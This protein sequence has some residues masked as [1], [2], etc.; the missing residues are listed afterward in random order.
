MGGDWESA[1]SHYRPLHQADG[2]TTRVCISEEYLP[3]IH[4][5]FRLFEHTPY[6]TEG[7]GVSEQVTGYEQD[8]SQLHIAAV[9]KRHRT[10][11]VKK[12]K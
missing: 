7:V 3:A 9:R 8:M 11:T 10:V 1:G 4:G 5:V 12:T 6:F 2:I